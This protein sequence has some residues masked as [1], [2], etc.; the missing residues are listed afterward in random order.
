MEEIALTKSWFHAYRE[1]YGSKA[2]E[3]EEKIFE[4][5][6][7]TVKR[8]G[9]LNRGSLIEIARWKANRASGYVKRNSDEKIEVATRTALI[10]PDE[11]AAHTLTYLEGVNL[12]MASAVMTALRPERFTVF[13]VNADVAL[14]ALGVDWERRNRDFGYWSYV[15]ACHEVADMLGAS[16][17]DL[18]RALWACGA[19]L[20]KDK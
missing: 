15:L 12:R 7:D 18:D 19:A 16:L 8:T 10:V 6:Q 13:D 17:R 4:R 1:M 14:R 11:L 2:V 3:N 20:S 5:A 9:A